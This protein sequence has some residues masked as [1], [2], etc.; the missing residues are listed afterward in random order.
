M[1]SAKQEKMF[2]LVEQKK[3]DESVRDFCAANNI[4]EASYYYW[5]KK[6]RTGSDTTGSATFIPIQ[7]SAAAVGS[8]LATIQLPSGSLITVYHPE[9]FSYIQSLL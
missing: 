7:V 8:A 2:T 9:A 4:G 6:F 3:A 5:Q 1:A